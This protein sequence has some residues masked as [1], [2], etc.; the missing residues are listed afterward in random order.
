MV[1]AW[2]SARIMALLERNRVRTIRA[3]LSRYDRA[4]GALLANGLAYSALFAIVPLVLVAAGLTGLVVRDPIVRAQVI[5]TIANVLPPLRGLVSL[6]LTES[7][8]AA[9]TIS[10]IGALT[11][12]WGGSRFILAFEDATVRIAGGLRTRNLIERNVLGF[13]AALMLVG[14]VVVGAVLAALAAF[15]DAAAAANGLIAVSFVTQVTL[16]VLPIVLAIGGV[17]LVY[18][19]VFEIHPT[20]SATWRPSW[21][22]ALV[23]TVVARIFVYIAPR[24]IGAAATIGALATAFAALAWL[25]ISFQAILVGAAWVSERNERRLAIES[26]ANVTAVGSGTETG[27]TPGG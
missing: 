10:I 11:L 14:S 5:D 26:A 18:R 16:A 13:G 2:V 7:A 12:V 9:G 6:V 4:G 15:F 21:V 22:V 1:P 24:L 27:P 3:V 20:W 25:S 19:Y 8:N 23:L 17:A